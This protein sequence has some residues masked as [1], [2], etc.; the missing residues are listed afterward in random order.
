M[1]QQVYFTLGL[2]AGIALLA[3]ALV[4]SIK[5]YDAKMATMKKKKG[6]KKY[7]QE[8]KKPGK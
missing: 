3:L 2:L 7:L 6:R 4:K 8:Y 1:N 5:K